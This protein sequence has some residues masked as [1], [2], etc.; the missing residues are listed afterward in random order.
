MQLIYT[1]SC[2]E[3][4]QPGKDQGSDVSLVGLTE[5]ILA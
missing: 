5:V 3:L 2:Q 1:L 4:I